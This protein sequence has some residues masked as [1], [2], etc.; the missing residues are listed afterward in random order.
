MLEK[1]PACK[2]G[3]PFTSGMTAAEMSSAAGPPESVGKSATVEKPATCSM[4]PRWEMT[5]TV[6][7]PQPNNP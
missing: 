7:K 4:D 5:E 3:T 6:C 1:V 2:K